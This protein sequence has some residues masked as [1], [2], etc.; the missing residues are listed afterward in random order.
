MVALAQN[1]KGYKN[2]I[3]LVSLAQQQFYYRPQIY[4]EDLEEFHEGI[5]FQS[6]CLGG[7][8]PQLILAGLRKKPSRK[9]LGEMSFSAVAT[10]ISSCRTTACQ[11]S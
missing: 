2:L 6:A 10:T 8:E 9:P 7:T 1:E 5:I 4:W 3:R 11:S